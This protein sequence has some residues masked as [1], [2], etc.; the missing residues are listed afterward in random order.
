M[1]HISRSTAKK[2]EKA[3]IVTVEEVGKSSWKIEDR[4]EELERLALSCGV[5]LVGRE[6]CRR[7][8]ITPNFFI[9]RGKVDELAQLAEELGA[10][11]VIFSDDLSPSQQR[12][13]EEVLKT[14]TIDRT[15]L[16]LE[17]F[18]RRATSNEG[19]VQVE[20]AQLVY[21][22]PRLGGQGIHLSR[23]GGGLGT[24]GPG[25]QKLEV[26]RRRIRERISRLK[27]ELKEITK[28]RNLM[29]SQR[30]RF[31]MLTVGLVGY[32][33]SGKSTLFNALTESKVTARDQLFSTLDPTVRKMELSNNQTVLLADTVGFLNELPHHLIESFKA[34][35]EEVVNADILF[36]VIDM[37]DGRMELQKRSVLE[38]L[39]ELGVSAKPTFTVLNKCDKVPDEMDRERIR[40]LFDDPVMIS[41]LNKEGLTELNDLIVRYIQRDMEDIDLNLPHKHYSVIKMIR[42]QGSV[43][44]EKYHEDGV[45][46]KARVPAKVKHSIF[47]RLKEGR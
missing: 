4:A 46:I 12:N 5:D 41:A 14:K 15:Q 33:N 47:R 2:I 18:A 23:I 37:S 16:I 27:K 7:K 22:L 13:L 29:R 17:I 32:T 21:L 11:V 3:I 38:V 34:T 35:L 39:K 26:D 45:H 8:E 6:I 30:E 42:D 40:R 25:E 10:D 43:M 31:S 20:L 24:K 1:V 19:K 36:H 28:H 9:G 44:S